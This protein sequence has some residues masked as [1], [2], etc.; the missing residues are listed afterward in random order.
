MVSFGRA[1]EEHAV[2]SEGALL[3][4]E[5]ADD[6]PYIRGCLNAKL[7]PTDPLQQK[8]RVCSSDDPEKLRGVICREPPFAEYMELRIASG[9]WDSAVALSWLTQI[10]LSE[11]LGVPTTSEAGQWGDTRSFYDVSGRTDLNKNA[12][13]KFVAAPSNETLL[14]PKF[15]GD[16]GALTDTKRVTAEDYVPCAHFI[17]EFWGGSGQAVLNSVNE[18]LLEPASGLGVLGQESWFVT[19]FTAEED[20]SLVSYLGLKGDKNRNKLAS[21]FKRPMTWQ[22]YCDEISTSN[23]TETDETAERYPNVTQGEDTKMFAEGLYQGYFQF[24]DANN[25]TKWP[26]NCTGHVANYPC[27]WSSGME[28]NIYHFDIGLDPNNGPDGS[29]S[30]YSSSQLTALPG[31]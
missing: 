20:P 19:K 16:C 24:T 27:G 13:S 4:D 2:S 5:Y 8:W 21:L 30:G 11:L 7:P 31:F 18:G 17:P 25:C 23:C 22:Q 12:R 14:H 29:P 26:E 6:N 28:S 1:S 10:I 15:N 9:N 3:H